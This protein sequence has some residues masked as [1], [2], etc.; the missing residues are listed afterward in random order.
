[1]A[2]GLFNRA[3]EP[4]PMTLKFAD[5][6]LP[7]KAPIHFPWTHTEL[8]GLAGNGKQYTTTVPRH[9]VVLMKVGRPGKKS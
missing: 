3:P 1:M 7:D 6:G 9:G 4:M 2:V 8:G 5:L